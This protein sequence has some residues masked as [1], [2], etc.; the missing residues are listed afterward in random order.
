M[1]CYNEEGLCDEEQCRC[2]RVEILE[3][4]KQ[5]NGKETK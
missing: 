3:D 5:N 1:T 4:N 2:S